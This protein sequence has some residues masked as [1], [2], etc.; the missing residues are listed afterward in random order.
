VEGVQEEVE[1]EK[2]GVQELH[3]ELIDLRTVLGNWHLE[4]YINLLTIH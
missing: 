3:E 2:E 4:F 1:E